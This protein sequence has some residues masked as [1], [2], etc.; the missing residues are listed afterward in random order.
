MLIVILS[1]D[2]CLP[3]RGHRNSVEILKKIQAHQQSHANYRHANYR[4]LSTPEKHQRP[5]SQHMQKGQKIGRKAKIDNWRK[6]LDLN[7]D[8]RKI[9]EDCSSK[10]SA[11]YPDGRCVFW[12]LVCFG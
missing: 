7:N 10:V 11:Q 12:F 2:R 1:S 6:G 8:L 9:M 4:Y 3:C 5:M